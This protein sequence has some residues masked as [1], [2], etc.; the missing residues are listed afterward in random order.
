MSITLMLLLTNTND[1]DDNPD[2][3]EDDNLSEVDYNPDKS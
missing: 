3:S 2:F 1:N